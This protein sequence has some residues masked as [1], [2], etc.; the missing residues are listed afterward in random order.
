MT[1]FL[2]P[3]SAS[4]PPGPKGKGPQAAFLQLGKALQTGDISGAQEAYRIIQQTASGGE[5][6]RMAQRAVSGL[7][8]FADL[9]EA[10]RK[11]TLYAV[12][13]AVCPTP[14][15]VSSRPSTGSYPMTPAAEPTAQQNALGTLVNQRA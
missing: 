13:Q 11:D 5:L 9:E 10:V 14:P 6:M 7:N 4:T 15:P 12:Q 3:L 2:D 8:P 1:S